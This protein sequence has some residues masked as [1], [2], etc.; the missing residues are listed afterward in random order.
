MKSNYK[1]ILVFLWPY[2]RQVIFALFTAVTMTIISLIPPLIVRAI[3]DRVIGE[4]RYEILEALLFVLLA[5]PAVTAALRYLNAYTITRVAQRVTLDIRF[6]LY[7]HV[8]NLSLRF[9][10]EMGTGKIMSRIMGDVATIQNMI[11]LQTITMITDIVAFWFALGACYHMNW[12]LALLLTVLFP[13][14]FLNFL[15]FAPRIRAT[16]SAFRRKMDEISATLQERLSGVRLVKAYGREKHE[17]RDFMVQ[18]RQSLTHAMRSTMFGVSSTTGARF[19]Q[20][21]KNTFLF[22]LGC[23]LVVKREMTYGDVTAFMAYSFRVFQPALNFTE[24]ANQIERTMVSVNRIFEILDQ[25]PEVQDR[26][27]AT[28][29]PPI[30]GHVRFEDVGFDYIPGKFVL[31]GIHLNVP[32]GTTV[33]LVGHTGCGKTT[34]TS[35]LLRF[36]D[37]K[38]GRITIDG[39]DVRD[40]KVKSLRRQIGQVLQ[41]SV[42]FNST[43]GDNIRY[44][45]PD[46]TEAEVIEAARIAEIHDFILHTPD[47]YDTVLGERG[48]KLSVGE[49]QRLGIARAVITDPG[50]LVLDEATASLDSRSEALIQKALQRVMQDRTS[51]VIAHRLSTIVNADLIV[52]MDAGEILETGRHFELLSKPGSFYKHLYEQQYAALTEQP[53]ALQAA[54]S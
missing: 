35:M 21:I 4:G 48:I 44:G 46:A 51:F 5:V 9:H 31:K 18:T 43:L 38:S 34:L 45:K 41:D 53:E 42:V 39:H 19:F 14:Y 27:G 37:V 23:Y 24:I 20:G 15:Y 11:N 52:V 30:V 6:G 49:K 16:N 2:R 26:P 36:Y 29:L 25:D 1:K 13:V 40:V 8:L 54:G 10:G 50:I 47:G 7:R 28:A 32:P 12:K 22:S 3:V 17:T 33:A